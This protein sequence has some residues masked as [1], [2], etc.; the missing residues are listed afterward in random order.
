MDKEFV[1]IMR[2]LGILPWIEEKYPQPP[3]RNR[4]RHTKK[5]TKR[6]RIARIAKRSRRENR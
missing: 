6:R 5:Q 3:D 1:N 2:A 4:K